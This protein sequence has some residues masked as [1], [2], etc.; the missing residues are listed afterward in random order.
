MGF[1]SQL[2]VEPRHLAALVAVQ[3]MGSFRGAATRLECAQSAVSQR[4]AQL[5]RLVGMRLVDRARGHATLQLTEAGIVLCEHAEH[6][7]AELDAAMADLQA[8]AGASAPSLRVGAYESVASRILPGA[9]K[10]LGVDAPEVTVSLHEDPDWQRFFPLV[11]TGRLDAAFADLPLQPGPF[12]SCE[13]MHDTSVLIVR[14]DSPLIDLG[15]PPTL[16]EIGSLPLIAGSWPM[17]SLMTEHLRAAGV[18]P[19]FVFRAELNSGLQ[20][21]VAEGMGAALSPR[22]SVD[23]SDGRIAVIPLDGVLPARRIALYWQRERKQDVAIRQFLAA[24]QAE[25]ADAALSPAAAS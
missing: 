20:S 19:H 15:R 12:A 5:E 17:M 7:L 21:L 22:L 6:I 4:I 8:L 13:L 16:A 24:L 1:E 10:R 2:G 25:C 14:A 9:L 18:E 23:E 11:A 3:Q